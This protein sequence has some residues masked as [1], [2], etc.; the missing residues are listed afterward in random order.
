M[1]EKKLTREEFKRQQKDTK[2]AS[3]EKAKVRI[4]L[5]PIWLRLIVVIVLIV[6]S[7]LAGAIVG[8]SVIG[9]GKATDVFKKSTWTHIIDLV[10]KDM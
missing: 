1:E 7:M 9:G 4:R 5:I 8:Y 10:N 3:D 2:S 6:I